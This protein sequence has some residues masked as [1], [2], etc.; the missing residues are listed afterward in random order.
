M[1]NLIILLTTIMSVNSCV[2]KIQITPEYIIN[3]NWSKQGNAIMIDKL[4]V[5]KDSAIDP[6]R[7]LTHI[8]LL[9]KLEEDTSYSYMGNV[10]YNGEGYSK[11]KVFFNKRENFFWWSD[12][13]ETRQERIGN[14][15]K[16]NW[17]KFSHLLGYLYYIFIYVDS[18][19]QVHRF[20]LNQG[21]W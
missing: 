10:Q 2:N 6:F 5:K 14:L 20:D 8:D 1:K 13:G 16:N 15:Q 7:R 11:R 21:N 19:N 17:Y 18:A 4:I 9:T 12:E 3:P